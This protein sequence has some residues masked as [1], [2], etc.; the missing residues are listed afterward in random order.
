M[1]KKYNYSYAIQT[2]YRKTH[3]LRVGNKEGSKECKMGRGITI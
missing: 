2:G 3:S 1:K